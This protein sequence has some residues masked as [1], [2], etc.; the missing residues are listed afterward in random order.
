MDVVGQIFFNRGTFS[1]RAE[2][3]LCNEQDPIR[4][5]FFLRNHKGAS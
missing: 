3:V 4:R 1:H 2:G 5:I